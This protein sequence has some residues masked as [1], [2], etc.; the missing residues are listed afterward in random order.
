MYMHLCMCIYTFLYICIDTTD[1]ES[2][3][4][5]SER[6]TLE[7]PDPLASLQERLHLSEGSG[8]DEGLR[9]RT[10]I[11]I[12]YVYVHICMYVCMYVGM[13]VCMYICMYRDR[14]ASAKRLHVGRCRYVVHIY[15]HTCI[16]LCV[17]G[18]NMKQP[19]ASFC[20]F[21]ERPSKGLKQYLGFKWAVCGADLSLP[22]ETFTPEGVQPQGWA[23]RPKVQALAPNPK[24]Q[25][26]RAPEGA[27][28]LGVDLW[29]TYIYIYIH[30]C[31][32]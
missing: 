6:R 22:C 19:A 31:I 14:E 5:F 32:H 9:R 16:C 1:Y 8:P 13:Y 27:G 3:V 30:I 10:E 26:C 12:L 24:P 20:D 28:S 11:E 17:Y 18:N 25:V 7:H 23:L 21:M 4:A 15:I 2:F 29:H